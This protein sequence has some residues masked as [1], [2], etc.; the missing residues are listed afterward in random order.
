MYCIIYATCVCPLYYI[1]IY[2]SIDISY[3]ISKYV[4]VYIYIYVCMYVCVYVCI[5]MYIQY[6]YML[7]CIY[8][9]MYIYIYVC[10][11]VCD[12]FSSFFY[13]HNVRLQFLTTLLLVFYL[14]SILQIV[15]IFGNAYKS[16][17][18]TLCRFKVK[19]K[20]AI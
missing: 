10:V 13:S 16:R 14:L 5:C 17:F 9:Y 15:H 2:I 12:S 11:C 18:L 19:K 1:Y 6:I 8:M 7:M 3:A 4:C 20:M